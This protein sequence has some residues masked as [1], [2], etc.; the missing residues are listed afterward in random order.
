VSKKGGLASGGP[1]SDQS[2]HIRQRPGG[3]S[4]IENPWGPPHHRSTKVYGRAGKSSVRNGIL[5][6]RYRDATLAGLPISAEVVH[7]YQGCLGK[8]D[9]GTCYG[10]NTN[11]K[12]SIQNCVGRRFARWPENSS[13]S[14]KAGEGRLSVADIGPLFLNNGPRGK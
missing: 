12:S 7:F 2:L 14:P 6:C 5:Q 10:W 13:R 3:L 1:Q 9:P 8:Y 4:P 11:A